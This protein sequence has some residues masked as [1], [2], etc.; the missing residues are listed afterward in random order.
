MNVLKVN[1]FKQ[2][3]GE[4]AVASSAAVANYYNPD[5]D[6]DLVSELAD[7]DG[8]GL[9]TP[10]NAI[11]LNDLGFRKVTVVSTDL[12][13]LDYN[14]R[15]LPSQKLSELFRRGARYSR[16][17]AYK[18]MAHEYVL[19]LS[20]SENDNNLVIDRRFGYH[21][22]RALDEGKP[23]IASFNWNLFFEFP[24]WDHKKQVDPVRGEYT[25]HAVV[26]NGYDKEGVD[27]VDSHHE[28]YHGRLEKYQNGIYR[29]D[30]E[31]LMTVIG[32]VGDVII[33]EDYSADRVKEYELV[34]EE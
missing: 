13:F 28:Q 20:D 9:T 18:E 1:R 31:T 21:I 24:K 26:I 15:G 16:S 12:D 5:I 23:V 34:Q 30:W 6:Y 22:R 3:P 2:K 19:F 33:P 10:Q 27:I 11:L 25:H 4:C 29:M 17:S 8:E 14:W 32:G 7:N